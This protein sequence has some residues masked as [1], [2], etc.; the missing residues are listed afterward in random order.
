MRTNT[1][2]RL[3]AALTATVLVLSLSP[4]T[5]AM[6][7]MA[8]AHAS[9]VTPLDAPIPATG[10]LFVRV[11]YDSA[12][13]VLTSGT[14]GRVAL[15]QLALVRDG[16]RIPLVAHD[17]RSQLVRLDFATQ[18][19]EG[20]HVLEGFSPAGIPITIG[21]AL[22]AIPPAPTVARAR[23]DERTTVSAGH[24]GEERVTRWTT[25][26][27]LGAALP[28]EVV[29]VVMRPAGRPGAYQLFAPSGAR[30]ALEA[31]GMLGGHCGEGLLPGRGRAWPRMRAELVAFDRYG[32]PSPASAAFTVQ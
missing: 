6:C 17:L 14:G 16:A 26:L 8:Q 5:R 32:R 21:G 4:V 29:L 11:D 28:A 19:S 12:G 22:P 27:E 7:A 18:P 13:P 10:S 3:L 30:R 2:A 1:P 20:E 25:R 24:R 15:P 31:T 9:F 23:H